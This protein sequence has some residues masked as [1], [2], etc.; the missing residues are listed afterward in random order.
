MNRSPQRGTSLVSDLRERT[1][2]KASFQLWD[3][4]FVV[5]N[6]TDILVDATSIGLYPAVDAR[7]DVNL[8]GGRHDL[9]VCDVIPNPPDTP[10]VK[11]A[12]ALGLRTSTGLPMLVYQGTI[13]FE[14]W[15]GKMAPESVMTAALEKAF[16]M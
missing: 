13:G 7:P 9:L 2:V 11:T 14:M 10:F 3:K 6:E 4:T 15:T 5:D 8:R 16:R 12:R 1:G